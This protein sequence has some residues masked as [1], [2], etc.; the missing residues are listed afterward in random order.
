METTQSSTSEPCPS[1]AAGE[2]IGAGAVSP[3]PETQA[4]PTAA[5]RIECLI[6]VRFAPDGTVR[7]IGERPRGVPAQDWFGYLCRN[8]QNC[9]QALSGGRG[10]FR[11]SR[12]EVDRLKAACG[13]EKPS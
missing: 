5:Q 7:E 11:L 1:L 2:G 6:H 12:T 4:A 8:T 13:A 3:P 10:L 9:Y